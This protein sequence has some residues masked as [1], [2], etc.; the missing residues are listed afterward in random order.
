MPFLFIY[1][2]VFFCQCEK[3]RKSLW[4]F[5]V[6]AVKESG[7]TSWATAILYYNVSRV[8]VDHYGDAQETTNHVVADLTAFIIWAG[9]YVRQTDRQTDRQTEKL[10]STCV[11]PAVTRRR[12]ARRSTPSG[13]TDPPYSTTVRTS[14]TDPDCGR[15]W[16]RGSVRRRKSRGS[17]RSA[18][19]AAA[20][21]SAGTYAPTS[22]AKQPHGTPTPT[23][24]IDSLSH[25]TTTVRVGDTLLN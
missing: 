23:W 18:R 22:S 12:T 7:I 1:L 14:P 6:W 13:R 16:R 21:P 17:C 19:A 5:E 2:R 11:T 9:L 15:S 24:S 10:H 8:G 3:S 20:S 25:P 4:A